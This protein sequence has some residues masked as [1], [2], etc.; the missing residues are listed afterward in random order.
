MEMFS[1]VKSSSST[2]KRIYSNLLSAVIEC[3]VEGGLFEHIILHFS[4]VSYL[5]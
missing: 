1:V 5:W 3:E 4:F 2:K